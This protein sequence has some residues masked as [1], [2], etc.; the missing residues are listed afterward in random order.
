MAALANIKHEAFANEVATCT[1]VDRAYV[2]AG[3]KDSQN[4]R[5]NGSR[6][7]HQS[8]VAERIA[9]LRAE[10]RQDAWLHV[11]YL[12]RM[13]LPVAEAKISDYYVR[14]AETQKLRLKAPD[15]M[16]PDQARAVSEIS[17]D[18]DTPTKIKLHGKSDASRTLLQSIGAIVEQRTPDLNPMGDSFGGLFERLNSADRRELLEGMKRLGDAAQIEGTAR[19]VTPQV[20][21]PP[22]VDWSTF[23]DR[24]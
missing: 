5:S 2:I 11:E 15:E 20:A 18:G 14:D 24:L 7:A 19:D 22:A 4:A 13:L 6:L 16:T 12:Q 1:P 8:D 23:P 9:E 3:F 17:F 10:F 21:A